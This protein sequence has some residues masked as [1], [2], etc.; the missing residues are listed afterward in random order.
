M[1]QNLPNNVLEN[2]FFS[3]YNNIPIDKKKEEEDKKEEHSLSTQ[4]NALEKFCDSESESQIK[5]VLDHL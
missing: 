2:Y 4:N 5:T 1:F 3:I